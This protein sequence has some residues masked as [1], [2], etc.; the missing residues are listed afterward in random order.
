ML[1]EHVHLPAVPVPLLG[2][3]PVFKRR[4]PIEPES[5]C[6]FS[7]D[8]RRGARPITAFDQ[9]V[10]QLRVQLDRTRGQLELIGLSAQSFLADVAPQQA[11]RFAQRL[12]G[13]GLGLVWP[14]Q[15]DRLIARAAARGRAGDVQE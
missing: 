1:D 10:E 3:Q 7:S 12:K 6:K 14:E 13:S 2:V 15:A 11:N 8:E 4:R 9:P 5:V